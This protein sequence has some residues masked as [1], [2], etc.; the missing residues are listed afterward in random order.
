M[1][2]SLLNF[3]RRFLPNAAAVL[4]LLTDSLK[5]TTKQLH[6]TP[7]LNAP[8]TAAKQLLITVTPLQFPDPAAAIAVTMDASDSQAGAV[9]QQSTPSGWKPLVFFSAKLTPA[10][11]KYSTFNRELLAAY[12]AIRHFRFLLEGRH[13]QLHT[14][15]QP[16]AAAMHRTPCPGLLANNAKKCRR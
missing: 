11:Q 14:D 1:F 10:Q 6:W 15:H 9:L 5:G 7:M 3:Y 12:L 8:F 2:P 16:L 4:R 13:F